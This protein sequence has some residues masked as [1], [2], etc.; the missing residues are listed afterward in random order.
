MQAQRP[1]LSGDVVAA[2]NRLHKSLSSLRPPTRLGSSS[3]GPAGA[4]SGE[5][6]LFF[7]TSDRQLTIHG[8]SSSRPHG[9]KSE[10][11]AAGGLRPAPAWPAPQ[12]AAHRPAE[13]VCEG[14]QVRARVQAR[15]H[16]WRP[17]AVPAALRRSIGLCVCILA[18]SS[19]AMSMLGVPWC[20]ARPPPRCSTATASPC[21]PRCGWAQLPPSS[22]LCLQADRLHRCGWQDE[23]RHGDCDGWQRR[24]GA[25]RGVGDAH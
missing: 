24:G 10:H 21:S 7:A 22:C 1:T 20:T 11:A 25:P 16:P 14:M 19:G 2:L 4:G 9:S 15:A 3:A 13:Q 8:S 12:L 18:H 17:P 6:G 23:A 5:P